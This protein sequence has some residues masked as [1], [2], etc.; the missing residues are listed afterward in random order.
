MRYSVEMDG[1]GDIRIIQEARLE[2]VPIV[3][4]PVQLLADGQFDSAR[5]FF[6]R[7]TAYY[8]TAARQQVGVGAA[9]ARIVPRP[10]Q[11]FVAQRVLSAPSPRFLLA[12]EVGLGKT[13][14]AGLI[15]QELR[16]RGGLDHVLVIT[17]TNLSIQWLYELRSKFN[18][19]F[20]LFDRESRIEQARS[21]ANGQNPW[22]VNRNVITSHT[23]LT[24]HQDTWDELLEVPWDLVI[25]DEAHH[26]RR[27]RD[28]A[29]RWQATLL[30]RFLQQISPRSR[31]L[32]LLTAT[33]MQLDPS[34]LFSL[35]ELLDP[36]LFYSFD[37]FQARRD[38]NRALNA[39]IGDVSR[40][41][42]LPL[43]EQIATRHQLATDTSA[44]LVL[45]D[46]EQIDTSQQARDRVVDR[47]ADQ[48]LLSQVM[49]RN[50]KRLIGGFTRRIP[51][52]LSVPFSE[53][54]RALYD[55][56][57]RFNRDLYRTTSRQRRMIIG[58][59]LIGYQRRLTS[60]LVAFVRTIERRIARLE[61]QATHV[62]D[63]NL[64]AEELTADD[65]DQLSEA[66][67]TVIAA[68]PQGEAAEIASLR[69]LLTLARPIRQD[70]KLAQLLAFL[71]QVDR[72]TYGDQV[73]IFTQFTDTLDYLMEQLSSDHPVVAFHGGLSAADK[74][75]AIARFTKGEVRIL[76]TTEA[77]GEGRNLQNCSVLVN[78]DLPW[79]PMKIEQR[80]GRLD[81]IGQ[82]RNVLIVN[83]ALAGTVEERML[84]VLGRRIHAF[85]ETIG[86][87]DP[88][89]GSMEQD[90]QQ[91]LLESDGL[92]F[93]RVLDAYADRI[94]AEV[95][96]ARR[97]EDVQRDFVLDRRSFDQR[98][99]E[100]FD[101]GERIRISRNGNIFA[102]T[103][104]PALKADMKK[105]DEDTYRVWFGKQFPV[106][107]PASVGNPVQITFSQRQALDDEMVQFGSLGH[108]LFDALLE[109][110]VGDE[111]AAYGMTARRCLVS[112]DHAGFRGFQFTFQVTIKEVRDTNRIV[113]VAIDLDGAIHPELNALLLDTRDWRNPPPGSDIKVYGGQWA[114][115]VADAHERAEDWLFETMEGEMT[116]RRDLA[117]ERFVAER[118][119][120]E[121]FASHRESEGRRRI[122][123][124]ARIVDRLERSG[125]TEDQRVLPI[126][127]RSLANATSRAAE[128]SEERTRQLADLE[129]Q[130]Q[131][132][133]ST[134]L[135]NAA[136]VEIVAP[137][138][139]E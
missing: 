72:T 112:P 34:E 27:S 136:W 85:E 114:D 52:I 30:F 90:I 93:D 108:P 45:A 125:R 2:P 28:G 20:S 124:S 131:V 14:E 86:G 9:I 60:S 67:S 129:A 41:N 29:D 12:D 70:A 118:Q 71:D 80:I 123:D 73:V 56:L 100:E 133:F 79:N 77:G 96:Q 115:M 94:V 15:L 57:A 10:H 47:L 103:L 6:L 68:S 49:I 91:I 46:I 109:Y 95:E 101:E 66:L 21:D 43:A 58:F 35:V 11:T 83:F 102:R 117:A 31:G 17:P 82:Q 64:T 132:S 134:Q 54:E 36:A 74:D 88:I 3:H 89:L 78:Y 39:L 99:H 75:R 106:Q 5:N 33:P 48:H 113:P 105:I 127:R 97:A 107:L 38:G 53:P 128:I 81:R 37:A 42:E 25:V 4:S 104:L 51:H 135:I 120:I 61:A 92:S 59:M 122:Q 32:L 76:V 69:T 119:K 126:W 26:A 110:C 116:G 98:L 139:N 121:R 13:I 62:P 65:A 40:F 137:Y 23:W 138:G 130:R 111:F 1:S 84:D 50:R 44:G 8:L 55:E 87:L 22:V 63:P 16:A 19:P 24:H 7:T 18:E